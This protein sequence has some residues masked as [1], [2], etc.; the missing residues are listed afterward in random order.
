MQ[1][2]L[3]VAKLPSITSMKMMRPN[4]AFGALPHQLI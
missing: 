3:N 2:A 1:D 4:H